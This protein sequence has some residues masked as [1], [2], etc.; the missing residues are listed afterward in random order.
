M[1][2]ILKYLKALLERESKPPRQGPP[3]APKQN[4]LRAA[5]HAAR[6]VTETSPT[7]G[8]DDRA[9]IRQ[10]ARDEAVDEFE[11]ALEIDADSLRPGHPGFATLPDEVARCA[12]Y[13]FVLADDEIRE[14]VEVVRSYYR[15][16]DELRHTHGEPRFT[17]SDLA[18]RSVGFD[19]ISKEIAAPLRQAIRAE[20]LNQ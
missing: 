8:N 14:A 7:L 4:R 16:S 12:S 1:V 19:A 20:A 11:I 17:F 6:K 10:L 13:G 18:S 9:R 5:E 15:K 2:H 3:M